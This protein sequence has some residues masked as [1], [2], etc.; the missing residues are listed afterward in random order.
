[1][2]WS[3]AQITETPSASITRLSRIALPTLAVKRASF[4]VRDGPR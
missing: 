4:Q 1:M 3:R 2:P